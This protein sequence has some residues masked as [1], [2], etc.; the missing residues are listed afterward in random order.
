MT[1]RQLR[2]FLKGLDGGWVDWNNTVD[3]FKTGDPDTEIKGIAVAWMAYTWAL[4]RALELDC[5]VFI[6]HEPTFYSHRDD[7]ARVDR[8]EGVRLKR[9]WIEDTGIVILR[10]HDLWDQFPDIGIPDSW[11]KVLGFSNPVAGSGYYR[12][13]DVTGHTALMIAEM[14]ATRTRTYGQS[15][16]Q[17]VGTPSKPVTR[18]A[19]G[20]GAITPFAHF[21]DEYKVDLAICTD[22]GFSYWR[23]GALAIDLD[24]PVIIVNHAV[25][26]LYGMRLLA[27][28]LNDSL[29]AIPVRYIIESCMYHNVSI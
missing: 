8:F 1:A 15:S 27:D 24:I 16:V 9:Q 29:P 11:A 2:D 14:V 17:I 7:D 10:C 5:N 20:T 23:D 21:L 13:Y 18:V 26:E 12:V 4:K 22:D 6:T 3:T 25:A 28:Y 19:I